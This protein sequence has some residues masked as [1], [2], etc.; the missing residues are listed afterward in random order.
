M[1]VSRFESVVLCYSPVWIVL[2]HVMTHRDLQVLSMTSKSM[3]RLVSYSLQ[4]RSN[5]DGKLEKFVH[6][7][8]ILRLLLRATGAVIAG[9]FTRSYFLG[10]QSDRLDIVVVDPYFY[11]SLKMRRWVRYLRGVEGY[12]SIPPSLCFERCSEV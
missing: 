3:N 2:S 11:E 5:I 8:C 9:E 12:K 1:A 4:E 10:R 6:D 7:P